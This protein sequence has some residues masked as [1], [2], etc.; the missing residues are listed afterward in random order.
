MVADPVRAIRKLEGR[1]LLMVHGRRDRT[2]KPEQADAATVFSNLVAG[3]LPPT[4]PASEV[5]DDE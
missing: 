3:V 2:V 1:P 5:L 4:V